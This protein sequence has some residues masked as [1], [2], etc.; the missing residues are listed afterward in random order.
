M[1]LPVTSHMMNIAILCCFI[2]IKFIKWIFFLTELR[3][4]G[5]SSI[6]HVQHD[7]IYLSFLTWETLEDC[8][9]DANFLSKSKQFVSFS[10]FPPV[11]SH[12]IDHNKQNKRLL[13]HANNTFDYTPNLISLHYLAALYFLDKS[14][15][16]VRRVFVSQKNIE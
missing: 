15:S 3:L 5:L 13:S 7:V 12:W 1:L 16:W 8:G 4:P 6:W 9:I 11:W 2:L 14:R 10:V